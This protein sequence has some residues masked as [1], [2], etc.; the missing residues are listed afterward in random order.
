MRTRAV[1]SSTSL[2]KEA[3]PKGMALPYAGVIGLLPVS[4]LLQIRWETV[5]TVLIS[6][7]CITL[8][9]QGKNKNILI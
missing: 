2:Y 8:I 6:P 9:P 5:E 3:F 7:N 4:R 1:S